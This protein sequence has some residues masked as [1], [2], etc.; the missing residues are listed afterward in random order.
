[1]HAIA[2]TE[3]LVTDGIITD[4]QARTI[5]ARAREAMVYLAINTILCFGIIAAT[6]GLIAWLGTPFSVAIFGLLSL[7]LGL[8][9]LRKDTEMYRMFGN[10]SALIGASMLIIGGSLELTDQYQDAAGPVM[11]VIG[12]GIASLAVWSLRVGRTS[13]RFLAGAIMLLGLGMHLCGFAFVL[14]RG[15]ISGALV[16]FFYLYAAAALVGA[17]WLTDVRLVTVLAI[18]PFAQALDTGTFYYRAYY[19]FYSPETTLSIIQMTA[20]VIACVWIAANSSERLAR[21]A[22]VLAVMAFIVANLCALVGSLWGDYVGETIW[23]PGGYGSARFAFRETA[24]FLSENLYS[25]LWAATLAVLALWAAS[26]AQRGLFNATLT[27][28]GIHAYTQMFESFWDQP[29]TYVI[30]GFA[31][32]PLAWG[33]WRL[34]RWIAVR[35]DPKERL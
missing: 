33:M 22:R 27:F 9:I 13:A 14:D 23:G 15:D 19:V 16:S 21:H 7:G 18:V 28:A 8:S 30:G 6:G 20:L 24:L 4:E 26:K 1:M 32:I 17:G 10:A 12:L 11:V 31:A 34:D 2:D 5:E 3:R 29:L 25:V 35:R